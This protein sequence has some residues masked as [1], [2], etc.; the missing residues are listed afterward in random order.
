MATRRIAQAIRDGE[1]ILVHGDYDVDG[2]AGTALLTR[3]IR[4]L[5]GTV[6]GFVPHRIKDG[7]DFGEAGIEAARRVSASLLVTVD[8]GISAFDPI[9]RAVE[10]GLDVVVTDHHAPPERLPPALAVVNPNRPD[11]SYP[12]KGLSGTGV[13][14]KV[15]CLLAEEFSLPLEEMLPRLDL[16]ALATVADLVPLTGENR[17]LVRFGVRAFEQTSLPGLRALVRSTGLEG[18]RIDAGRLGWVIGPRINATGRVGDSDTALRLLLSDDPAE[19]T[20]LAATLEDAN[21]DRREV[22]QSVLDEALRALPAHFD[23]DTH[24]SVVLASDGWHPGVIGIVA[25]RIVERVHRP[26]VLIA[27]DGDSGR[28]SARSIPGFNLHGALESCSADLRRFGGHAG[29]AG[30]DIDRDRVESFRTAFEEVARSALAG[31]DLRPELKIDIALDPKE[32]TMEFVELLRHLGPFGMGN[33]NPV[34]VS[35]GVELAGSAR[36]VG[37]GHL[38]LGFRSEGRTVDAIGFGLARRRPPDTV[39][40]GLWDVAYQLEENRYRGRSTVQAK[41]LDLVPATGFPQDS[42]PASGTH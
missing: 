23:P 22:D 35:R 9:R 42:A 11:C 32:A 8:C 24:H 37:R 31:R 27:L 19:C 20:R 30:M 2:I 40:E 38:K 7:Y 3:F 17:A 25:S 5:G 15:C 18:E 36:E 28:G 10:A 14:F 6:E 39:R 34:F 26:V 4:E 21:T 16:V 29:A 41:L 33:R 12:N 1:S 13:A